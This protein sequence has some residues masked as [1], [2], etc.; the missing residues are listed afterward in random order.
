MWFRLMIKRRHTCL[1]S[2]SLHKCKMVGYLWY[3]TSLVKQEDLVIFLKDLFS[4]YTIGYVF[5]WKLSWL[6][7][8]LKPALQNDWYDSLG[9]KKLNDKSEYDV[10]NYI[11][12][13]WIRNT[14]K[15][16]LIKT[17]LFFPVTIM[18]A[19]NQTEVMESIYI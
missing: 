16:L 4:D 7:P 11:I 19:W 2:K 12:T 3:V 5:C 17:D 9:T 6:L 1:V 8:W 15:H 14:C 10:L 13:S 18:L